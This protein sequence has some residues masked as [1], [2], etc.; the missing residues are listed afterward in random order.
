MAIQFKVAFSDW[1]AGHSGANGHCVPVSNF[2]ICDAVFVS[3]TKDPSM[4]SQFYG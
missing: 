1:S 4:E 2:L 3:D